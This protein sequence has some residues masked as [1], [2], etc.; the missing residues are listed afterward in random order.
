MRMALDQLRSR[1]PE[2]PTD[3][4]TRTTEALLDQ[5]IG[6]ELEVVQ[7]EHRDAVRAA[8]A[9]AVAELPPRDRSLLRMHLLRRL[10]IDGIAAM[11]DVHRARRGV[12]M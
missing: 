10:S 6:P 11:N 2:S 7:R 8:V 5:G 1:R 4:D 12:G 3:D 9:R